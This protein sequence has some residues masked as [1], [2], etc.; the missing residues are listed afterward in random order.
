MFGSLA[1]HAESSLGLYV[2]LGEMEPLLKNFT[3]ADENQM[4]RILQ[5]IDELVK[6]MLTKY[7]GLVVKNECWI[8]KFSQSSGLFC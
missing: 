4:K 2:Q 6:V 3:A 5:R 1:S 7:T 8:C